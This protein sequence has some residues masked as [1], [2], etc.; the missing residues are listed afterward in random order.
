MFVFSLK[1]IPSYPPDNPQPPKGPGPR[2][3]SLHQQELE[4]AVARLE[5]LA[6]LACLHTDLA[7]LP[8]ITDLALREAK[9][10]EKPFCVKLFETVRLYAKELPM[11]ILRRVV[12]LGLLGWTDDGP[13]LDQRHLGGRSWPQWLLAERPC[14][15]DALLYEIL[16]F[17]IAGAPAFG[18]D[19]LSWCLG[20]GVLGRR[21]IRSMRAD[22]RLAVC[23]GSSRNQLE[24]ESRVLVDCEGKPH[25]ARDRL[26]LGIWIGGS[27]GSDVTR[28]NAAGSASPNQPPGVPHNYVTQGSTCYL[29]YRNSFDTP[30]S[31]PL[32]SQLV[33]QREDI[34]S[35]AG[36]GTR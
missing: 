26:E 34:P 33:Y 16:N 30:G 19:M 28:S 35:L 25:V 36:N 3:R 2:R 32:G 31:V 11:E 21:E 13:D 24:G 29:Q 12:C 4:E 1:I 20:F 8:L 22:R 15:R 7:I 17:E 9:P 10:S 18:V 6:K 23:G 27:I 5:S 14:R